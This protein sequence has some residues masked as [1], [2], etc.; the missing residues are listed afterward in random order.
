VNVEPL[1]RDGERLRSAVGDS[2]PVDLCRPLQGLGVQALPAAPD[3]QVLGF[4][5]HKLTKRSP[6]HS[7]KVLGPLAQSCNALYIA[8]GAPEG[9]HVV[10]DATDPLLDRLQDTAQADVTQH[11]GGHFVLILLGHSIGGADAES[12][13]DD[14]AV[15]RL[16]YADPDVAG[17][18]PPGDANPAEVGLVGIQRHIPP[19]VDDHVFVCV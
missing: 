19:V 9:E 11:A 1:S 10:A 12:G 4:L 7:G 8:L 3:A 17:Q 13:A 5:P 6:T 15:T 18:I 16:A 14:A 2:L